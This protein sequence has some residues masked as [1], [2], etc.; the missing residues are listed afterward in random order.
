MLKWY[1]TNRLHTTF[2]TWRLTL[3]V[4]EAKRLLRDEDAPTSSV[5]TMVGVS[6]KSNFHKQFCKLVG[7]TPREYKGLQGD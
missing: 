6:D 3:R 1:F 2:R 4:E 7:M 5:H